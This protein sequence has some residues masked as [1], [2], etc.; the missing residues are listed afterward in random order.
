VAKYQTKV[1]IIL[2]MLVNMTPSHRKV[3]NL[4]SMNFISAF[5]KRESVQ[6]RKNI[7][8]APWTV[9]LIT[10]CMLIRVSALA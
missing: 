9:T 3:A 5:M 7:F 8:L 6:N 2:Y 1:E 10:W 4:I